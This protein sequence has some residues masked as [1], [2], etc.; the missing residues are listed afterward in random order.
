MS[1]SFKIA[2]YN[3]AHNLLRFHLECAKRNPIVCSF[4]K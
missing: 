1:E 2:E 4:L 3:E